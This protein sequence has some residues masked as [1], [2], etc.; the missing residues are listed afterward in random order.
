MECMGRGWCLL[1]GAATLARRIEGRAKEDVR[2][3]ILVQLRPGY[4]RGRGELKSQKEECL[5]LDWKQQIVKPWPSVLLQ[6][7]PH[8]LLHGHLAKERCNSTAVR[9]IPHLIW[10]N[11]LPRRWTQWNKYTSSF[12]EQTAS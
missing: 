4:P 10:T 9:L 3:D 6:G 2:G 7:L 12:V 8:V 5:V 1:G 11:V